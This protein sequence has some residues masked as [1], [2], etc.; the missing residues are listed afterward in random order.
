[1][2]TYW[3]TSDNVASS[4]TS[5]GFPAEMSLKKSIKA[6]LRPSRLIDSWVLQSKS[7]YW[8]SS[9]RIP[10]PKNNW[11]ILSVII[12][13][14][15]S[16]KTKKKRKKRKK[17][18]KSRHLCTQWSRH[19]CSFWKHSNVLSIIMFCALKKEQ[20]K[21]FKNK[22]ILSFL[23]LPNWFHYPPLP[24]PLAASISR[25]TKIT[26]MTGP[27]KYT[28]AKKYNKCFVF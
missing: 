9:V 21:Y 17:E 11:K 25:F 10:I 20:I 23:N 19:F 3:N 7:N 18:K 8:R 4:G 16:S 13:K 15:S 22:K 24:E 1:M 27:L 12:W 14:C 2:K 26:Q 6:F 5:K 28:S